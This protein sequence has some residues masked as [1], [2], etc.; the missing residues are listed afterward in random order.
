[1]RAGTNFSC[2]V[3]TTAKNKRVIQGKAMANLKDL[4]AHSHPNI[5][6]VATAV[7]QKLQ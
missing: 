2:V 4:E 3:S 1:M 6:R 5:P 7:L